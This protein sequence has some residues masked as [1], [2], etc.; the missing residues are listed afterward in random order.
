MAD[1]RT[2]LDED[3]FYTYVI[4]N[5]MFA[6]EWVPPDATSV[7]WGSERMPKL[8]NFRNTLPAAHFE[9]TAQN[10]IEAGCALPP[11]FGGHVPTEAEVEQAGRCS[12]DVMG[13]YYPV[14]VWCDEPVFIDGGWQACR[15]AGVRP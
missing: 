3:G 5:D 15:E 2:R 4:S 6:P 7:P 11:P 8:I 13:E 10:A 14:A 1:L 9:Q 12:Q